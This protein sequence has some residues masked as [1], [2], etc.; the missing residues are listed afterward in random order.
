MEMNSHPSPKK[1][2]QMTEEA[3]AKF[4][5]WL[6]PNRERAGEKYEDIRRRLIKIFVCRGCTCPEELSDETINRVIRKIQDIGE[7]YAGDPALYFFGVAHK[8]HFEYVRKSG[9]RQAPLIPDFSSRTEER[10]DC[11]EKC[12]KRLTQRSKDLVLQYYGEEKHAKIDVRKEL[13]QSLGIPINA[14]RIRAC[15]IRA[16]LENCVLECLDQLII[17]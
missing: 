17:E 12:M 6:S 15:R 11:L 10:Y 1:E 14:L 16:I 2:W 9:H 13:A 4:L 3:F 7:I 5:A 8:V